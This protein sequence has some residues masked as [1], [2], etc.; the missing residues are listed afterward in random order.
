VTLKKGE[1]PP[2]LI[3]AVGKLNREDCVAVEGKARPAKQAPGGLEVIPDRIEIVSKA[4]TPL[5]METSDK[6]Q[7]GLDK[8]FDFRYI[9]VRNPR[10]QAIFAVPNK[11]Q[12]QPNGSERTEKI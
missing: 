10:V 12:P 5:P 2:S 4:E 11:F 6:I 3:A 8:R 1:S 7:T 9:D